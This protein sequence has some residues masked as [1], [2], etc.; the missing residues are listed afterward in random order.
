MVEGSVPACYCGVCEACSYQDRRREIFMS[1][2]ALPTSRGT[3]SRAPVVITLE[4]QCRYRCGAQ[5]AR[6]S[7]GYEDDRRA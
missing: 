1:L 7:R 3:R 4:V 6:R 5:R 2:I